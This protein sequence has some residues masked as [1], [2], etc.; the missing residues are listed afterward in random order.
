MEELFYLY[1]SRIM[2][3][4]NLVNL[5]KILDKRGNLLIGRMKNSLWLFLVVSMSC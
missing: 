1:V 4:A 5:P 2:F 3:E